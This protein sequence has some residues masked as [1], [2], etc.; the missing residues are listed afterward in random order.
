M[1]LAPAFLGLVAGVGLGWL[2]TSISAEPPSMTVYK[3]ET[4][5]CCKVWVD[6]VREAGFK[7]ESKDVTN[8]NGIKEKM[9]VPFAKA[10]CHTA[11]IGKYFVE[12]HVPAA[13]IK[14]LLAEQPDAKG[15]TVP[16]MPIGSPGMEVP[17]GEV[18]PYEVLLVK[19]DGSTEVWA[20]YPKASR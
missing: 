2:T 10:S 16:A 14:R 12:G 13:E 17:S 6:H 3:T 19:N 11:Q 4:C 9:G 1:K 18:Q 8:L 15:L 20:K 7:A 5:G